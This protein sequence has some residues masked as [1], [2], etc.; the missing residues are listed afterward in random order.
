MPFLMDAGAA[1]RSIKK[2]IDKQKR[3]HVMP[4]QMRIVACFLR[5][6]PRLVYDQLFKR[7]PRKPRS[8]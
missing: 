1:A 3:F 7:A 5:L 4:W 6:L 8:L 2:A